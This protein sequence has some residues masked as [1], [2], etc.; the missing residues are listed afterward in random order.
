M[1]AVLVNKAELAL[2]IDVSATTLAEW[3]A[4][5]P[6]FPVVRRGSHG[7][8]WQF[9][10][11]AVQAYLQAR[12][13]RE[14][15]RRAEVAR[16]ETEAA[17][18]LLAAVGAAADDASPLTASNRLA[19]S[20]ARLVEQRI[21]AEASMLVPVADIQRALGGPLA[22]LAAFWSELGQD[23]VRLYNLDDD[24]AAGLQSRLAHAHQRLLEQ[25]GPYAPAQPAKHVETVP[26]A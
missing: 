1:D 12:R 9:D 25:L 26:R 3:I 10:P 18:P 21:A 2:V 24:C 22:A 20:R 13:E 11:S 8:A 4:A 7:V 19:L 6:E 16:R 14:R 23:L 17:L 5:D 15:D